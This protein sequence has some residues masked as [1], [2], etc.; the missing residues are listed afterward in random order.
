MDVF[1]FVVILVIGALIIVVSLNTD[2]EPKSLLNGMIGGG[3]IVGGMI[4]LIVSTT[5]NP[6][7]IDV[8][9]GKTEL[10]ITGIYKDSIFIPT[11]ST[12]IF[13]RM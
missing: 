7:A 11:D 5:K 3:L 4:G 9:R 8:Y 10:K 12:V 1:L 2:S 6:S 13:K